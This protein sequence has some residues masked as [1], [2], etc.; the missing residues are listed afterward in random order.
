MCRNLKCKWQNFKTSRRK[1]KVHDLGLGKEFI[2]TT[3]IHRRKKLIGWTL[4]K[5]KTSN[6]TIQRRDIQE[7]PWQWL[8][9]CA[10]TAEDEGS[11]PGWGTAISQATWHSRKREREKRYLYTH[12]HSTIH[13]DHEMDVT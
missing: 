2:N 7:I 3:V 13:S 11:I 1:Q 9:L 6:D 4:S 5:F 8:E 10:F 12:V